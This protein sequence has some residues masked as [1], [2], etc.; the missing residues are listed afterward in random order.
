M[1]L[2][3]DAIVTSRPALGDHRT[4]PQIDPMAMLLA[5]GSYV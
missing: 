2:L 5:H 3:L 4:L 1:A